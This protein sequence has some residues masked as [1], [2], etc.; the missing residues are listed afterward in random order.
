MNTTFYSRE[1]AA[2]YDP[3]VLRNA[4]VSLVGVG[5][6][7]Q[8]ILANL[9]LSQV[10]RIY[11]VDFDKFESHNATRSP[12]FPNPTE[13]RRWGRAKVA[14]A[15]HKARQMTSW[16]TV[17]EIYYANRPIQALGDA[18]FRA[19][20][21][22]VGAVD[23]RSA[24]NYVGLK[25]AQHRIPLIEGGFSG[26]HVNATILLNQADTDPCWFCN[27]YQKGDRNREIQLSC[28]RAAKL[29]EESGFIPAIQ[30]AAAFLGAFMTD[31]TIQLLHGNTELGNSQV[32]MDVRT[33]R[34][35]VADLQRDSKCTQ[36]NSSCDFALRVRV[37]ED[38]SCE[39]LLGEIERQVPHPVISLP[40]DYVVR[41]GCAQ[42]KQSI[43]VNQPD[44]VMQELLFCRDCGGK[45]E[46]VHQPGI[47]IYPTLC[48]D[49]ELLLPL[50]ISDLGIVPGSLI[51]IESDGRE[52]LCE[53]ECGTN[54][55]FFTKVRTGGF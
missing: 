32:V 5:A 33:G 31:V 49:D 24:R 37:P 9:A 22:V 11:L 54:L 53:L 21:L 13:S 1:R 23:N 48:H 30:P 8:N 12:F 35:S 3:D 40:F 17:P 27:L 38:A 43:A 45:W 46:P 42:C 2:G 6:L 10:D 55:P 28:T 39:Q 14:I 44:W 7:G 19:A 47:E 34:S 41:V 25:A 20:K 29:A 15:A 16:S 18:P 4:T 51:E 50:P 26:S 52:L 36:C